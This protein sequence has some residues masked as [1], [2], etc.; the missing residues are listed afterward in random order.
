[1][2]KI[3]KYITLMTVACLAAVSCEFDDTNFDNLHK[4]VDPNATYYV[5]FTNA[6]QSAET[7]VTVTGALIDIETTVAV[8]LMGVPQSQDISVNFALDP[9]STMTSDMFTMS[10]SSI[11]IPAGKTSGSVNFKT[12]AENMP[13][14]QTVKLVLN[15][16]AGANSS[17]N[18]NGTKLVYTLKR[19]EF[20]PLAN[21][22]ADFAGT[23]GVTSDINLGSAAVTANGWFA[24][25]GFTATANG[26]K[27]NI[28]GLAESFIAGF[29]GE[30]VIAGGTFSMDVAGNGLV[31]IPRQ[32]IYTTT[33]GGSPYDYEISGSGTWTNCGAKPTLTFTYDIFYPGDAEGLAQ[34]YASYLNGPYL[35]GTFTLN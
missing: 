35:G 34:S 32:Y 3:L 26:D 6:A 4:D 12:K 25:N 21:S 9:S 1:M 11:T 5:Q 24:E 2:K 19:I 33:Y 28:S 8:T 13:V 27:L 20:C 16:D 23:W 15:L 14:G 31:T 17:P 22:A 29:W 7:G 30:P 18:D 10:A